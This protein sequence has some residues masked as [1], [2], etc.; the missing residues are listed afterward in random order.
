MLLLELTHNLTRLPALYMLY[1]EMG[2]LKTKCRHYI[3]V[4]RFWNRLVNRENHRLTNHIFQSDALTGKRNW[5]Y[6]L[7]K[8]IQHLRLPENVFEHCRA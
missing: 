2:W 6:D 7:N 8:I 1:G 5:S 3:H 4:T